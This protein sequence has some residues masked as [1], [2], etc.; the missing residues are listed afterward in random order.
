M[1]RRLV[2]GTVILFTLGS[3]AVGVPAWWKWTEVTAD[4]PDVAQLDTYEPPE[5]TILYDRN[6]E[7]IG[8]LYEERRYVLPIEQIP[9]MVQNAFIAAED[10]SFRE[11]GGIDYVGILRAMWRNADE[12]RVA[13]GASTITQQVVRNLLL[14]DRQK[15]VERKLRE[16]ALAWRLEERFS[17]DYILYLY[18]NSIYMGAQ[19]YGV[20]AAARTYFGKHAADLTLGE[21]ALLAGLPQ[22]PSDYNPY[23]N[24][25]RA[26]LRETYVLEQMVDKGFVDQAAADAAAAEPTTL[27]PPD[28]HFLDNAPHFT[29]HV[30]RLLVDELGE[31]MVNKGGLRVIT[32]CDLGLQQV[33]Q[34]SVQSQVT[35]LDRQSGFRRAHVQ[36]LPGEPEIA[37]W[38]TRQE[39]ELKGDAAVSI[40]E[41]GRTYD[42]VVLAVGSDKARVAIG[43]HEVMLSI[44]DHRWMHPQHAAGSFAEKIATEDALEDYHEAIARAKAKADADALAAGIDPNAP[45]DPNAPPATPRYNVPAPGEPLL[46]A[47]DLIKVT[48]DLKRT[49]KDKKGNPLP[50]GVIYQPREL[51]GALF[52]MEVQTGAV[53]ALVGGADF[54]SS[55]FNRAIQGRRQVGSTFKPFVYGAA[56]ESKKATAATIIADAPISIPLAGG[57]FWQPKDYGDEYEG[58]M[59]IAKA[60]ALSKNTALVRTILLIDEGMNNDLVYKFARKLGLGGPPSGE[61]P[62]GW[63]P[64][65]DNEYLCPWT[66]E[67]VSSVMCLDH[68]PPRPDADTVKIKEHRKEVRRDTEH[69]CR[70]CDY[71]VGLGSTSLTLAE[72]VRAY[73]TYGNF[74]KLVEPYYIQ[75]VRDRHGKVIKT[76]PTAEPPQVIDPGVATVMNFM[77]QGVVE[78]GTAAKARELKITIAGKTGTTNEGRDAWFIGMTPD[79]ITGVWVGF[80]TPTPIGGRATGGKVAL[81]VWMEYMKVATPADKKWPDPPE[82]SV[83]WA[84]ISEATG[85]K[86]D[87]GRRYPFLPGTVPKFVPAPVVPVEGEVVPGDVPED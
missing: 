18:L 37:E 65:P 50:A 85:F 63:A 82:G 60:V 6:G 5:A 44:A 77:L 73:A 56:I 66:T 80:D 52:S 40:L 67:W 72:M 27:S 11:H 38:R 47:G 78:R 26:R 34:Q 25:D 53:R 55:Q 69:Y 13:Q 39:D 7:V 4:L 9:P 62:E 16:V 84:S 21:A 28:N 12:G 32:T 31:E 51:E 70:S 42:A 57:K 61:V 20:E 86:A 76:A 49:L 8:E 81:P 54:T 1:K 74:G 43:Q 83:E 10:A 68:Y 71:S 87:G 36:T 41:D 22:R 24:L 19:S 35:K 3:A 17:K 75:E 33:A 14:L 29:E 30:R 59:T 45:V 58:N 15:T 48:V 79:I 46:Q 23:K 64:Q 2:I